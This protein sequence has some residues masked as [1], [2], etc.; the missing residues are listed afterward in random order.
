[1]G[2][3]RIWFKLRARPKL[4]ISVFRYDFLTEKQ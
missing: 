1:M 3:F 4:T 2:S